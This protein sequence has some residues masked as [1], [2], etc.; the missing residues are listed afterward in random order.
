MQ[1]INTK[2]YMSCY[3]SKCIPAI[4]L[5]NYNKNDYYIS[6]HLLSS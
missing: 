6:Y 5:L 1:I 4:D 3:I 2:I